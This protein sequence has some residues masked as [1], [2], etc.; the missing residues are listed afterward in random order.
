MKKIFFI[1]FLVV[2]GS[3]LFAGTGKVEIS[4]ITT[5]GS[6]V[7]IEYGLTT[8]SITVT[9]EIS[10]EDPD[11]GTNI[12]TIKSPT[13][14]AADYTLTLPVNDGDASQM[15]QTDGAGVLSWINSGSVACYGDLLENNPT[16]TT[17]SGTAIEGWTSASSGTLAGTDYMT[18]SDNAGGDRLVVGQYGGG[19]YIVSLSIQWGVGLKTSENFAIIYINE[20]PTQLS[21]GRPVDQ[22]NNN[23]TLAYTGIISLSADDYVTVRLDTTNTDLTIYQCFL[24][25]NRIST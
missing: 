25:L 9:S 24:T 1:F 5:Q 12:V 2:Q 4:T 23:V 18:F 15:L 22:N 6:P 13:T 10:I 20:T 3:I 21:M 17:Y 16:G 14:L 19:V 8:A 11:A 7:Y